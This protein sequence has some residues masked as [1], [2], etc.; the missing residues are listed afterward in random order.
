MYIFMITT[1]IAAYLIG[2]IPMGY[3]IAQL[4][5]ITDIRSHGSG[6]IGATNVS[7][8][9]GM[10]YFFLVFLLDAGKAF[11]FI[12]M[13]QSYFELNYLCVFASI[14]LIGNG[15]S[16]F[17]NGNGGKG[18]A[19]LCGLLA[20]LYPMAIISSFSI[21]LFLLLVTN[22]VGIASVGSALCLPLYTY[23]INYTSLFLFSLFSTLWILRTH[24]LNI[25][26]Y[27]K[28]Y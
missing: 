3:L 6:N 19:T 7:R 16:I 17:L 13:I 1:G 25:Y 21:W 15:C 23:T 9:L 24:Q 22:T 26:A 28:K 27:W 18:V 8:L 14:L 12:H 2:A 11:L 10:R 4:K 20:G 5:G